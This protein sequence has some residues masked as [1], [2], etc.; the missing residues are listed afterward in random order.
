MGL[1]RAYRADRTNRPTAQLSALSGGLLRGLAFKLGGA[2]ISH[3]LSFV[4]APSPGS[5][6]LLLSRFKCTNASAHSAPA[7]RPRNFAIGSWCS[8]QMRSPSWLVWTKRAD[9]FCSTTEV[10]STYVLGVKP[11]LWLPV[12]TSK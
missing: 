9:F 7:S 8:R 11:R 1:N 4:G 2:Q 3:G 12:L 5:A 6:P 10:M